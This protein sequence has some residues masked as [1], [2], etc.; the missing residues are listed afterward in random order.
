MNAIVWRPATEPDDVISVD[1]KSHRICR[2]R[3]GLVLKMPVPP[4][5]RLSALIAK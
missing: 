5:R 1:L 4:R 2:Q 3:E